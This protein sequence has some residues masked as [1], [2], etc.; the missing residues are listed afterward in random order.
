MAVARN[1]AALTFTNISAVPT[2][3]GLW[4][5]STSGTLKGSTPATIT[6]TPSVG[7]TVTF[8]VNSIAV[9]IPN[10]ELTNSGSDDAVDGF[11]ANTL[12]VGLHTASP[13]TA[14]QITVDG[15]DRKTIATSGW[16]VSTS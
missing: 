15:D 1:N 16:T 3:L 2:H 6:P 14:N 4:S 11:I 13:T 9:E 12:Y 5:A 10:G 7:D 8:A